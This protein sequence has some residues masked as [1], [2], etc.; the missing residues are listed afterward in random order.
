MKNLLLLLFTCC[1]LSCSNPDPF[2][3]IPDFDSMDEVADY[4]NSLGIDSCFRRANIVGLHCLKLGMSVIRV[5]LWV[6]KVGRSP[7]HAIVITW[8][9]KGL[10]YMW[11]GDKFVEIFV[12]DWRKPTLAYFGNT[13]KTIHIVNNHNQG[14]SE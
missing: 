4:V 13:Y 5:D 2:S 1:L 3:S 10:Y 14:E 6:G 12:K 8:H 7:G 11:M 9:R